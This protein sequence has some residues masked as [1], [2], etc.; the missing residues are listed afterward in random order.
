M[1]I[2]IFWFLFAVAAILPVRW[3]VYLFFVG[4]A[5]GSFNT[6]P[7]GFNLTPYAA[8]APLLAV[9]LLGERGAGIR[10]GDALL[11][12]LRFGL[13]TGFVVYA[14]IVTATAPALFPGVIIVGLN[15]NL[16]TPLRY[17]MGNVSQAIYT[18][19]A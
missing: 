6:L 17:G 9:R 10:L 15:S 3:V 12:P 14:L 18:V 7:G 2:A 4:L 5:F 19:A 13:L 1:A 11:N 8:T 16:E